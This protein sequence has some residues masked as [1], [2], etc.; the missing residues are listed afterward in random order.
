[1]QLGLRTIDE[2]ATLAK[3]HAQCHQHIK[4]DADAGQMLVRKRASRLVGIDDPGRS[5]QMFTGQVVVGD[6]DVDARL[7]GRRHTIDAGDA[8]IDGDDD[9]GRTRRGKRDDFGRQAITKFE[10]VRYKE[11]DAST[12]RREAAHADGTRGGAIGVVVRHDQQALA[13]GNGVGKTLR[14]SGHSLHRRP[15]RQRREV[16]LERGARRHPAC[17]IDARPKRRHAGGHQQGKGVGNDAA[18]DVHVVT[19]GFVSAPHRAMICVVARADSGAPPDQSFATAS[20]TLASQANVA[21]VARQDHVDMIVPAF[22]QH[23][24]DR[25]GYGVIDDNRSRPRDEHKRARRAGQR[26][27]RRI[28]RSERRANRQM[29]PAR[30]PRLHPSPMR[31]RSTW[32]PAEACRRPRP[33]HCT[34]WAHRALRGGRSRGVRTGASGFRSASDAIARNRRRSGDARTPR[35]RRLPADRVISA[36]RGDAYKPAARLR[37]DERDSP[38]P[39]KC[40]LITARSA[41]L[42]CASSTGAAAARR[43][44]VRP[45]S[46]VTGVAFN[47]KSLPTLTPAARAQIGA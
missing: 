30:R 33:T 25:C 38:S 41:S 45:I 32:W 9:V 22:R 34:P 20:P 35:A 24:L 6:D 27:R 44:S 47:Q 8:V 21:V 17:C 26:G 40:A 31:D 18:G 10:A 43:T 29:H 2:V 11:V 16:V 5:R 39:A 28:A 12:Q 4:H 1:M 14:N 23:A 15:R 42:S 36:G 13:P 46:M 19:T 7:H 37:F 3:R